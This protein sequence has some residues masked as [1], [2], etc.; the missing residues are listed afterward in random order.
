[1]LNLKKLTKKKDFQN[2]KRG[3]T[4][5]VLWNPNQEIW[6][7]EMKGRKMYRILEIQKASTESEYPDEIILM[8][9][10]NIF[11]NYKYFLNGESDIVKEVYL[12][13][14]KE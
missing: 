10:G 7:K 11:F 1:M 3:D 4:L 2:L 5:I 13:E 8:K 6:D 14:E 9:K 12:M